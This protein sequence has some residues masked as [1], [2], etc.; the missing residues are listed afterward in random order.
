VGNIPVSN[1][2]E[3]I[4]LNLAIYSSGAPVYFL[5][6]LCNWPTG[7]AMP[8][9]DSNRKLL[10]EPALPHQPLGIVHLIMR[11]MGTAGKCAVVSLPTT[12][13]RTMDTAIDYL[14]IRQSLLGLAPIE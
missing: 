13:G 1:L 9:L 10:L 14:T 8:L 3:Q 4:A 5:P 6:G 2:F 7:E 12:D 11:E